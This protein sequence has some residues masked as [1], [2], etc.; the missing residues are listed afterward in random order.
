MAHQGVNPTLGKRTWTW[1]FSISMDAVPQGY[2]LFWHQLSYLLS[3]SYNRR[4]AWVEKDHNDHLGSTPL[5]RAGSPAIF[6]G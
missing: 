6:V 4:M 5:L 1:A 2:L 3:I